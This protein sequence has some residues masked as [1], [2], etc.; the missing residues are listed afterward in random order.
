M[1]LWSATSVRRLAD[2][3]GDGRL[4]RAS[5]LAVEHAAG[6]AAFER[7]AAVSHQW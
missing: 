6:L 5:F 2:A 4:T 1:R 3:A 7:V